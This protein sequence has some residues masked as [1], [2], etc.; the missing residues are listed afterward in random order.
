MTLGIVNY[1]SSRKNCLVI[2]ELVADKVLMY[3]VNKHQCNCLLY[4]VS[5]INYL[6]LLVI[7]IQCIV[8]IGLVTEIFILN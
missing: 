2:I 5:L 6:L 3:I 4:V 1:Q 8:K 7:I